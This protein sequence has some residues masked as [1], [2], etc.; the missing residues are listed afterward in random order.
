[1][2]DQI[3]E[4]IKHTRLNKSLD[5]LHEISLGIN[6]T[7]LDQTVTVL[8][9]EPSRNKLNR[10]TGRTET[11]KL[12]NFKGSPEDIG[13]IVMVKITD[14]KTFSLDGIKVSQEETHGATIT[15]DDP[16]PANS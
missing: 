8:A 1:M 2:E 14:A 4:E 6:K 15:H 5:L 13:K 10:L 9:E 12:V 11:G 7:Y 16:I 3:P